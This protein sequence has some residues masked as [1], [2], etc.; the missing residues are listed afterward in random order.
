MTNM[1]RSV[2][3]VGLQFVFVCQVRVVSKYEY[4]IIE[5]C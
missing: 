4:K 5:K 1:E 3:K 2:L